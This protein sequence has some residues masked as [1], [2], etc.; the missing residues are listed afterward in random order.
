MIVIAAQTHMDQVRSF[1]DSRGPEIRKNLEDKLD[2]LDNFAGKENTR[3]SLYSD[4]GNNFFFRME[5]LNPTASEGKSE[6]VYDSW[7]VGG[8]I[9]YGAHDSGVGAPQ[10][11]VRL[12]AGKE[13]WEINT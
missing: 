12:V 9:Y 13:G 2:Y 8:L 1:A 10:Y 3:C 5:R 6:P 11:S 7:F 4:G